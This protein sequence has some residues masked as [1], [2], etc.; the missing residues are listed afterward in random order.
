MPTRY[1]VHADDPTSNQRTTK[2]FEAASAGD[3]E[4][5]AQRLGLS[6]LAVE[7]DMGANPGV[8]PSPLIPPVSSRQLGPESQVWTGTP[9]H[10]VN[11]KWYTSCAL[12]VPAAAVLSLMFPPF[13]YASLILLLIVPVT[14]WKYL[15]V[16]S[17]R[18]T[19]TSQR[20]RRESGVLAKQLDE[21]E[22]YRVKDTQLNQTLVDRMLSIGS[23]LVLSSDETMPHLHL[24]KI[25]DPANFR[26]K[27]RAA[28]EQVRLARGVRELDI[29]ETK[30]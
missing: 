25:P 7:V 27:L 5:M 16:R 1:I 22:L 3:A 8:V 12:A 30:L 2:V 19:L 6:V 15:I 29:S 21:V 20:L 11:A 28:V 9:S 10:W 23:V 17:T 26:E 13:G 14:L 24:A 4:K 18:Y